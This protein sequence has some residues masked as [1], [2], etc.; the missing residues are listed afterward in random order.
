SRES[1]GAE[2][3]PC[4][5]CRGLSDRAGS[6]ESDHSGPGLAKQT[7]VRGAPEAR[8]VFRRGRPELQPPRPLGEFVCPRRRPV[9]AALTPP[10]QQPYRSQ[11]PQSNRPFL[12]FPSE[13]RVRARRV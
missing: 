8:R 13:S 3:A 4:K 2:A 5:K 11:A 10:E 1:P 6:G 12:R 9:S 7:T